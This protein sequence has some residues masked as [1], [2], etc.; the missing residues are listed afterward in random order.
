MA[1]EILPRSPVTQAIKA[2]R[3]EGVRTVL[4]NPNIATVQTAKGLADKVY[5]LPITPD[6]VTEVSHAPS[7]RDHMTVT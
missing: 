5:F 7:T 3:E 1:F 2:L 4:I 6:Y